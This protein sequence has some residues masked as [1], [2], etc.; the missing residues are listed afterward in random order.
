MASGQPQQVFCQHCRGGN[1][2]T[3]T[4]CMWCGHTI[5]TPAPTQG[6][7]EQ[8][9]QAAA[10]PQ[11]VQKIKAKVEQILMKDE[12]LEYIAVENKPV[13]I[14]IAPDCVILTNRRFIIYRPKVLGRVDFEDYIWRELRDAQ[15]TEGILRAT[16]SVMTVDGRK[17]EVTDL[18]KDQARRVYQFAQQMEEYVLEERRLREIEEKRAEA[19]GIYMQT[20]MQAPPSFQ[21]SPIVTGEA[22]A[23]APRQ[24]ENPVEKL[25]QLKQM[26]DQ[27]L[28]TNEIY[29]AKRNEILSKM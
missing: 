10:D 29:E 27:G 5:A 12:R 1:P 26:L 13:Q 21:S 19:G 8:S 3:A 20:P 23:P 28:I 15:I 11:D 16:F 24:P 18:P 2:P 22:A 6:A 4:V 9:A 17:I 7:A 25:N 14:N